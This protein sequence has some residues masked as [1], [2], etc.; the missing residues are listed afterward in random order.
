MKI[1]NWKWIALAVG[2]LLFILSSDAVR[3]YREKKKLY[4]ELTKKLEEAKQTN[5]KLTM[6]VHRLKTDPKT[7]GEIARRELGLLHPDEIEYR[8]IVRRTTT[9]QKE[10]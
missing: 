6:E 2:A 4:K 7:I 9:S 3:T 8:F 10:R 1:L 5:Q